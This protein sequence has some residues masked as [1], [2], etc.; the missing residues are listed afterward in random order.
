MIPRM[1]LATGSGVAFLF[2]DIE[3][4]TKSE[5]GVGS[6]MWAD[7]VGRHD[8]LLRAAIEG[9]GG[10]VVKTEGDAFFASFPSAE[11]AVVAAA[12]AQR[13]VAAEAWDGGLT[14]RVRMGI[15]LGEGRLRARIAPTDPEDYVGIDVNYAARIATAANGGQIVLSAPL[16]ES[17]PTPL[18]EVAGLA[19]VE[20]VLDG[21][22]AVK[23]FEEPAPL[24]R[25]VVPG[26]AEDDRPL[27]TIDV[28]TNLPGDVTP[29]VGREAEIELVHRDLE[30]SRVVTLTGPGG[31]GKTRLAI[32]AARGLRDRYPH[33][34]WL[35]DLAAV[36]DVG[37]VE[38]AVATTVGV[39]ESPEQTM[40]EALHAHLRERTALLLLD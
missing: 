30:A 14:I 33:G 27:R 5:R 16:V 7:V 36:A 19:D 23:D 29:L 32:A 20:V 22:R 11:Q 35:V 13:A 26:A 34:V 10:S 28:P 21:L 38:P 1:G 3:G 15:H 17:L 4:S 6:A 2:T 37:L 12:E 8:E 40:G 25:L 9:Q 24:F 31:S 39:R 18:S